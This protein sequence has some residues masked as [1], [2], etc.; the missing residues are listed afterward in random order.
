[1]T[2]DA[3]IDHDDTPA[4]TTDRR[5]NRPEP[6]WRRDTHK[7]A[8]TLHVYTSMIAL[9]VV[10]FFGFS[11]LTLNHPTWTL[12]DKTETRTETGML[13]ASYKT[14]SGDIDFLAVS[15]YVR[16]NFDVAGR[17]ESYDVLNGQGT[18][19]YKNPGY[20]ADLFFRTDT[21]SFEL[22][23]EQQGW[24]GV[25][26]DLHKGRDAR[27]VWKWVIDI[28][29]VFLVLISLTGLLMQF[30]LRKRRRSALIGAVAGAALVIILMLITL[31]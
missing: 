13:P 29:A 20:A 27:P 16:N 11:G 14:S 26:N 10:L 17:V 25:M 31:R 21:G 15:E 28:S 3:E 24:V 1:M 12:G 6:R 9:L 18:I 5:R 19:A 7:W 30:F 23:I 4:E 8:R 2:T 22:R